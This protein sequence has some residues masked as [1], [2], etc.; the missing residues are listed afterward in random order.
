MG[1]S[2]RP[3]IAN[4][5]QAAKA[6]KE[7]VIPQY[8]KGEVKR[9]NAI[10]LWSSLASTAHQTAAQTKMNNLFQEY[11]C[12]QLDGAQGE[13]KELRNKLFNC[14]TVRGKY[15]QIFIVNEN[16]ELQY[17]GNDEDVQYQVDAE[18]FGKTFAACK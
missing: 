15:P 18:T 13:N 7:K 5:A 6:K 4:M 14:S 10:L 11:R 12:E 3:E 1:P 2:S 17:I 16:D 8:G 9:P